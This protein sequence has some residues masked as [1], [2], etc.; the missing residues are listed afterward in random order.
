MQR[1]PSGHIPPRTIPLRTFPPAFSDGKG[2]RHFAP[3][4]EIPLPHFQSQNPLTCSTIVV[5]LTTICHIPSYFLGKIFLA[6]CF[7]D[8]ATIGVRCLSNTCASLSDC[9]ESLKL[10]I[11]PTTKG[12]R[13]TRHSEKDP[14]GSTSAVLPQLSEQFLHGTSAQYRLCSAILLKLYKS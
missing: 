8:R 14:T 3:A 12:S 4:Q 2:H 13:P 5:F 7:L 1:F 9:H 10:L 11:S 6:T